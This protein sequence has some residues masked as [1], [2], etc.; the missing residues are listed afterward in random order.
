MLTPT[1]MQ[2]ILD[3]INNR[4][5][6]LDNKINKLEEQF[7]QQAKDNKPVRASKTKVE[8]NT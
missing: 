4:F 8:E 6:F 2:K 1:E 3:Q 5:N 7:Q